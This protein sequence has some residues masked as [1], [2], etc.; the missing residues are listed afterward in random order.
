MPGALVAAKIEKV[1]SDGLT[2]SFLSFFTG[3]VDQFH[4]AEVKKT[5]ADTAHDFCS[6]TSMHGQTRHQFACEC[7]AWKRDSLQTTWTPSCH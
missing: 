7:Q 1:L 3:T 6:K 4:L 2:L 5:A